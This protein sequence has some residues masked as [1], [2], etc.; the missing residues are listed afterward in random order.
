MTTLSSSTGLNFNANVIVDVSSSLDASEV[1]NVLR[2]VWENISAK[3]VDS[4][5]NDLKL[6][7][8]IDEYGVTATD[9][10]VK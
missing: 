2:G 8:V 10:A 5:A 1:E 3:I 6:T 7:L 9:K 4:T